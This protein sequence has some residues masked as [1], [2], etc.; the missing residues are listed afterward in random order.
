MN[1][2]TSERLK[3]IQ[4]ENYIWIIYLIIIGLSYY[5]NYYEKDYFQ[6]NNIESKNIYR[7]I[8]I[9]IFTMLILIYAYFE[10]DAIN[11]FK[12][13]DKSKTKEKYDTLILIGTTA[14][15]LSGAI[16][17]YI[18]TTDENLETEIAFS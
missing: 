11:N 1:E 10:K 14:V 6:T 12:E 4:V 8:N 13:K 16:F 15:L 18:V 9:L 3:Q 2:N 7:K 17:L 5:S